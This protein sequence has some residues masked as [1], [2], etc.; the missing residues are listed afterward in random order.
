MD[1][2]LS[3]DSEKVLWIWFDLVHGL[4]TEKKWLEDLSAP[5][6]RATQESKPLPLSTLNYWGTVFKRLKCRGNLRSRFRPTLLPEM[7]VEL[8]VLR[9]LLL[10]SF[11]PSKT[12]FLASISQAIQF[13]LQ[14]HEH[15][16]WVFHPN[17]GLLASNICLNIYS[18]HLERRPRKRS[19]RSTRCF[20]LGTPRSPGSRSCCLRDTADENHPIPYGTRTA[21]R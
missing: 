11:L 10:P 20:N 15:Q 4:E 21:K 1:S 14:Q 16:S 18:V 13:T 19:R 12:P 8:F 3:I 7:T 6:S 5:T 2:K 17:F 9:R